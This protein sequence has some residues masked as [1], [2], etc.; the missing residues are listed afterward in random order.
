[1]ATAMSQVRLVMWVGGG[2]KQAPD[3]VARAA[4]AQLVRTFA[5]SDRVDELTARVG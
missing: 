3:D 4:M 2:M 5:K 1:M